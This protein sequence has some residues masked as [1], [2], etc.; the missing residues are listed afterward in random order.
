VRLFTAAE[1]AVLRASDHVV[2]QLEP[3]GALYLRDRGRLK[4][5]RKPA[6]P[7]ADQKRTDA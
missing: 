1:L 6:P 4:R 5:R 3:G 7:P 2:D